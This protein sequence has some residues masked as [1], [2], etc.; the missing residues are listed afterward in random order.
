MILEA[1]KLIPQTDIKRTKASKID[2]LTGNLG[3]FVFAE[4]F[5]GDFRKH[6]VGKNKGKTDFSGIEVKT[7]VFPFNPKLNLLVRE[8]YAQKRK[9][10]FYVQIII[11]TENSKAEN[12]LPGTK[13]YLCGFADNKQVDN[14]PKKDF[15]SKLSEKGGYESHFISILELKPMAFLFEFFNI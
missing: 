13:A 10:D 11:D 9:P 15:G 1:E 5:F 6:N 3:E 2:T 4:Y 8:D 12:I 7:S 14:S